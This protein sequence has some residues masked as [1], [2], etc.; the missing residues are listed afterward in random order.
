MSPHAAGC[1]PP[2][3]PVPGRA[4][5]A[6]HRNRGF[7]TRPPWSV[8][9]LAYGQP[10]AI[11]VLPVLII[12]LRLRQRPGDHLD[13]QDAQPV[14]LLGDDVEVVEADALALFGHVA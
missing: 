5:K 14:H 1:A 6:Q 2:A 4:S 12:V 9:T 13:Q 11:L 3:R 8:L 7:S 10:D